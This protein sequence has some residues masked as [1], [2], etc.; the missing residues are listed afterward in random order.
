MLSGRAR[1]IGNSPQPKDD[2]VTLY[3]I[4]TAAAT[5]VTFENGDSTAYDRE[6]TYGQVLPGDLYAPERTGYDF[7]DYYIEDYAHND[8]GQY[9]NEDGEVVD[10]AE[11]AEVKKVIYFDETM[12]PQAI[13]QK[14]RKT[15]DSRSVAEASSR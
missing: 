12:E 9:L 5:P 11:Q 15:S 7:K 13:W 6:F 8:D 2:E 1:P 3:A 10:S 4:W 14:H